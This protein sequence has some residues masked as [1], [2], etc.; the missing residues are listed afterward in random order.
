MTYHINSTK[1]AAVANE[2][3]W[4]PICGCPTNV[5]VLLLTEGGTAIVGI[6]NS[7][8]VGYTHWHPLPKRPCSL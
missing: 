8:A 4:E 1:T 6:Y 3:F 2:V 5:K 7:N